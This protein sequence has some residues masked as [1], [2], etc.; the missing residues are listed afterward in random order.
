MRSALIVLPTRSA[1]FV[2]NGRGSHGL[3]EAREKLRLV[4]PLAMLLRCCYT[5]A[6]E[7]NGQIISTNTRYPKD[8][9][10]ALLSLAREHKRSFN[11]EVMWALQ[12]YVR[13]EE[14]DRAAASAREPLRSDGATH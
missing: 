11:A 8:L 2:A 7:R 1:K 10:D 4:N 12:L 3:P 5:G 6:M 9:H 14:A 13:Q